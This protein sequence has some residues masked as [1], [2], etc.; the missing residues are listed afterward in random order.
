V[1]TSAQEAEERASR[2]QGVALAFLLLGQQ[3]I[4]QDAMERD[5]M[6]FFDAGKAAGLSADVETA[7]RLYPVC[8]DAAADLAYQN[9]REAFSR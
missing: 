6:P 7:K 9:T 2:F 5:F 8:K 3:V 4:G 1:T